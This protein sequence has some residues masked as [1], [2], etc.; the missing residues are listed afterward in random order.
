MS[1]ALKNKQ[2]LLRFGVVG[3][4]NTLIDFGLLFIFKSLGVPVIA[5][6]ILSSTIAF[7]VS[8]VVNKNY[9]FKSHSSDILRQMISFTVVTLFGLWVIQSFVIYLILPVTHQ[10]TNDQTI[11][12]LLAKIIASCFSLTWNYVLYSLVVFKKDTTA[13]N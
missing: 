7:V 1:H 2:Q 9:T 13:K 11:A 10:F 4:G 12:L 5:A 8:F 6:N 3:A